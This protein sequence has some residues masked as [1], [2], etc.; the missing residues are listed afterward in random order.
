MK[1]TW[2]VRSCLEEQGNVADQTQEI[3]PVPT[4]Q[5]FLDVVL[6]RTQRRL[7]TQIRAGFQISRIRGFYTRKV[8]FTQETF[9]EKLSI[10]LEGFPKLQDI[11]PFRKLP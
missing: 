3:P 9:T 6:S 10:I 1:T 11:H 4:S 5:E 7:P 2:K 8:K